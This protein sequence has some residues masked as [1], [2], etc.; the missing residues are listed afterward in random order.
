[1]AKRDEL[2]GGRRGTQSTA[3]AC[4]G[5]QLWNYFVRSYPDLVRRHHP[6]IAVG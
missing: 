2:L 5:E 4:Y 6:D 3:P 1:M